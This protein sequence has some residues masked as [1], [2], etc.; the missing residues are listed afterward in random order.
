MHASHV[1]ATYRKGRK[2]SGS[3]RPQRVES[4]GKKQ[5]K[6]SGKGQGSLGW[7]QVTE[8]SDASCWVLGRKGEEYGDMRSHDTA[9]VSGS[10]FARA[11]PSTSL[12]VGRQIVT[13]CF[14]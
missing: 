8:D 7:V 6:S 5:R 3:P 14:T 10:L 13:H 4:A 12:D 9:I 11:V 1:A 2:G